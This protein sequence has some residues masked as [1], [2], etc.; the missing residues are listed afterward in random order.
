MI[1]DIIANFKTT[2][3][4]S[5]EV[6]STEVEVSSIVTMDSTN[7]PNGLY[8]F[9]IGV[10]DKIEHFTAVN[11]AGTLTEVKSVNFVDGAETV[12]FRKSHDIGDEVRI[13]NH[14][15]LKRVIRLLQGIDGISSTNPLKYLTAPTLSNGNELATV[16]YVLSVV[17][18]GTVTTDAIIIAGVADEDLVEKE[19]VYLKENGRW[20]KTDAKD[21]AKSLGIVGIAVEDAVSGA[22]FKVILRGIQENSLVSGSEYYLSDTPGELSTTPGTVSV[23]VG[24]AN[25]AGDLIVTHIP[26]IQ[27]VTAE[28]KQALAGTKGDVGD[29]NRYVTDDDTYSD[30]VDQS[31]E[32]ADD[33]IPV[34]EQDITGKNARIMQVITAGHSDIS[35]VELFASGETGDFTG[36]IGVEVFNVDENDEPTGVAIASKIVDNFSGGL[37]IYFDDSYDIIANNKYGIVIEPTTTDTNNHPNFFK[38]TTEQY[39]GGKLRKWN[40]TDGW[41]DVDSGTLTFKTFYSKENRV[42]R[43]NDNGFIDEGLIPNVSP[44]TIG[45]MSF[46][47]GVGEYLQRVVSSESGKFIALVGSKTVKVYKKNILQS[48]EYITSISLVSGGNSAHTSCFYKDTY[49]VTASASQAGYVTVKMTNL[50]DLSTQTEGFSGSTNSFTSFYPTDSGVVVGAGTVSV[51]YVFNGSSFVADTVT[52]ITILLQVIRFTISKVYLLVSFQHKR[53]QS[54]LTQ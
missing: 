49:I 23:F 21:S 44:Q 53:V 17:T 8:G 30:G 14:V 3:V 42:V 15:A 10:N 7:I 29:K 13:T 16:D 22:G 31:D 4:Q 28:Q 32:V 43:I 2:L 47:D 18:G 5:V 24:K 36:E 25:S 50:D 34:G 26:G 33:S 48:Y 40:S 11:D 38:D 6:G 54:Y 52:P 37:K 20:E 12:G 45:G 51:D 27:T 41:Q 19:S 9:T 1:A 35:G 39:D 46:V